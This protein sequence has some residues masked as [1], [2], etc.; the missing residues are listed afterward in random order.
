MALRVLVS[1]EVNENDGDCQ[2]CRAFRETSELQLAL[3]WRQEKALVRQTLNHIR[4]GSGH[5]RVHFGSTCHGRVDQHHSPAL[6]KDTFSVVE[7]MC[8]VCTGR[9]ANDLLAIGQQVLVQSICVSLGFDISEHEF[10]P[11]SVVQL[12]WSPLQLRLATYMSW[13]RIGLRLVVRD[14]EV[15]RLHIHFF[16]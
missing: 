12:P 15:T 16:I 1:R 8:S 9:R 7:N 11:S 4:D 3:F 14:T 2:H 6:A 10:A 5:L 13:Q